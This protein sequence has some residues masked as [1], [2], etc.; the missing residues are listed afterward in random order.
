MKKLTL[1]ILIGVGL[2]CI[3]TVSGVVIGAKV[4]N[5]VH[6]FKPNTTNSQYS[7]L[8]AILKQHWY[9]E[10][11]YGK[12]V[13]EDILINQFIGAL[14]TSDERMLDPYTYLRKNESV[15]Q[16]VQTGKLGVTITNYY[17]YPVV[18]NIEKTGAA[19]GNLQI[20]DIVL[21]ITNYKNNSVNKYSITDENM[22]FSTIFDSGLDLVD[23][24]VTIEVARFDSNNRLSIENVDITL[25]KGNDIAY[26]YVVDEDIDNTLMVKL[27][28]FE[29]GSKGTCPQLDAILS[30][31]KDKNLIIDLRDNGGG[32]LSSVIDICDL[33]LPK[34]K[35]ITT[36][37]YKNNVF[38]E[39]YSED[40]DK[41]DFDK[42]VILQ[43]QNTASASEILVSTLLYYFEDKVTLVGDKTYGKGIAQRQVSVL[44]NKYTL[45]YTCAKWLRPDNTWIGMTGSINEGLYEFKPL[46]DNTIVR[47]NLL[48]NMIG[49]NSNIYYKEN[50]SSYNAFKLDEVSS[51]NAYFFTLYNIMFESNIRT[52]AYF[53]NSCKEAIYNYQTLKNIEATG[54]MN[55]I[56]FIHFIK[57]RY[58]LSVSFDESHIQKAKS[59]IGA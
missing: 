13:D 9:S 16:G 24:K 23:K 14:S 55:E 2:V 27:T 50:V 36:L 33:F 4:T 17:S 49:Y 3:S 45:Q 28:S 40:D 31:N 35:L 7:Q 12:E 10:I 42:I 37:T 54:V 57:D 59:I 8:E 21:S 43:N 47:S 22:S 52:D 30:K 18:T 44:D 25:K 51:I 46:Q 20:G 26:S 53:D 58:D 39:H 34:D 48:N 56:T 15:A 38:V 29:A 32:D 1:R 5:L 41:Y 19:Y 11:Y 6:N